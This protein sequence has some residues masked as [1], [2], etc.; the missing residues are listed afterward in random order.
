MR[1]GYTPKTSREKF[2]L[3]VEIQRKLIDKAEGKTKA[4][5]VLMLSTG[6]HPRV[7]SK[8][9]FKLT[10]NQDY[11]S[12]NR[13][14]TMNKVRGN[15][16][17]AM[18]DGDLYAELNKLRNRTPQRLWQIIDD[19]G[20]SIKVTGLCPLQ[21]RHTYFVNRA[22]LGHNAFDIAHGAATDLKT[23]YSFYT[24][25]MGESKKLSQDDREFL[26]WLMEV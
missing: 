12:W 6:M 20:D 17:K 16:S 13:P 24:I 21:L 25:G 3:S 7:L 18:R 15:W 4:L 22:R 9:K 19:L 2:P 26:E 10:W 11:Y 5:L 23:V 14:K 8:S 1:K